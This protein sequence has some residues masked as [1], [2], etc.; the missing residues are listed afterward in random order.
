MQLVL[1]NAIKPLESSEFKE[2]IRPVR[3]AGNYIIPVQGS[4]T[5]EKIDG[6][7]EVKQRPE[8]KRVFQ[9]IRKGAKI[10]PYP[11]F[12]GYPGFIFTSHHSYEECAA[13]YRELDDELHIIYQNNLT[14][15]IGG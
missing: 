14:G 3:T 9:F 8:V 13:F 5:F 1:Q 2:E 10:L 11:H 7:E 6:L 15:T 12:S 4:G